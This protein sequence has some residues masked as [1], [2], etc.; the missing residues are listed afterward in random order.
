MH[1]VLVYR[2]K[3][4]PKS[5]TF[6]YEQLLGHQVVKPV[7]LTRQRAFNRKQ[8]PYSPVYVRKHM[9]GLSTWLRRKKIKC[10]HAR[11]GPA[12]L[13]LLPYAQKSKLPLIT[14]FHGFDATKRVKENPVYRRSLKRLFRKGQAFTVVSNHMRKRLIHLGCPPSKI[15]LIR[16]GID[17]RKFPMLPPQP[18]ENGEYRLLSVGRLTEKKGMDTL[19]KAFTHV[20]KKHPK[21]K[22]IIVGDGEEKKKLKRLIKKNN[23]GTQVVLKGALPHREVQRELAKCHLF[24]IACKTARNGNQEGIPNVIMEAMASGRPVISTYHAG[25]PE[26]VENKVTGYLVPE[27]SPTALGKMINR[28]LT[29]SHEWAQITTEARL[30]VEKNHDIHK[31]RMRLEELYLRVSKK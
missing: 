10:L 3:F 30:K 25:I 29:D 17:L 19:I 28:V 22:L 24:I 27:K 9:A 14:S 16:S 21:A 11:F 8:F 2:R 26:L 20:H 7:V 1:R 13:E 4:L 31:Q 5:E 15:T 6:I 12:G 23:L 18:V